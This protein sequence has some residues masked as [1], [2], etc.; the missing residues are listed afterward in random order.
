M[1][2]FV[3]Q[4][5]RLSYSLL[6]YLA[7]PG[8]FI[9]Y[10]IRSRKNPAYRQR[11]PERLGFIKP[12]PHTPC[13]WI[14]TV[15][16]GEFNGALPLINALLTLYPT[17]HLVITTTTVTGSARVRRQFKHHPRIRHVYAPIDIPGA[18]KR[19]LRHANIR[20]AILM[21]TELWPNLVYY[22]HQRE[23]PLLL[24]NAR[25]SAQSLRKYQRI[26]RITH[27]MLQQY[28]MVAVQGT[29]D[30]Q[31]LV[32]LG[33]DPKRM[34]ITGN[35]K[36]D[37][38]LD[39]QLTLKGQQL[40]LQ[41][42]STTR[43]T[44][45]AASTH[46]GEESIVLNAFQYIKQRQPNALLILVPRHPERCDK[47][48]MACEHSGYRTVLRSQLTDTS[49]L[50]DILLVN[51]IGELQLIY[52][53]ADV[54][55]VG[56]SLV[57]IGGHNLIEPATVGLPILTGPY[58]H[59]FSDISQQLCHA[60]GAHIIKNAAELAQQTLA[61]FSNPDLRQ[62]MGHIAY[63]VVSA[64]TGALAKH[65]EWIQSHYPNAP[66]TAVK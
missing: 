31:R 34:M 11:W 2:H 61:L 27:N 32:S 10:L 47:I 37:L 23:I 7:L 13:I 20:L 33:L 3:N 48:Q 39:S 63:Q 36:F 59:N 56:G 45:I 49:T 42:Q 21:E 25:L 12:E 22:C 40:R 53:T 28:T 51:T 60:E 46:D 24:A 54:A 62:K 57:P 19:F 65:L 43:P 66:R 16:V 5:L 44:L 18:V 58:L 52:T 9:R 55:F 6:H 17:H 26:A 1:K 8:I 41:W 38:T 4:G 50:P 30:G 29:E 35:I 14:H 64:N 15:S